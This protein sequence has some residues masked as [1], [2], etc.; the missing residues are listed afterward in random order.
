M[1][2]TNSLTVLDECKS[3][4]NLRT[5]FPGNRKNYTSNYDYED[6]SDLE[7]DEN[8]EVPDDEPIISPSVTTEKTGN[9]SS[10]LASAENSNA[11]SP[12]SSDIISVSDLDSLCSES[13]DT[14]DEVG[15]AHVGK[16]VVIEDVAFV[17]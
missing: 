10:E 6:D 13:P 5:R 16:V 3:K 15:P 9:I 1:S 2:K 17:T 14:K 8:E 4:E 7:E 12:E 11:K